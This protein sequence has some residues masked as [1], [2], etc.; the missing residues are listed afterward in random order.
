[1]SKGTKP[2]THPSDYRH[3]STVTVIMPVYNEELFIVGALESVLRSD[4]PPELLEI[5]VADGMSTDGTR[6]LIKKVSAT[7]KVPIKLIDNKKK[8]APS[9]LNLAISAATGDIIVRIDGHCEIESD[10]I[11]NCVRH[12]TSGQAEGVGGPIETIGE[13]NKAKA[14]STAMSSKFGVG[15][16][17]FR[18]IQDKQLYVD[19]VAF[20]GY[21]KSTL[22]KVGPF[23]EELVRNQ[24]D[25]YNFRIRKGGGKILLSPDI[26]SKYFSRATFQ[27]LWKQYFEY[28]FWKIRVLQ[29]HPKQMSPRQFVPFAF[30]VT[31]LSLL[32][33]S[34]FFEVSRWL[35]VFVVATY[36]LANLFATVSVWNRVSFWSL[37]AVSL[38]FLILHF[39]Y[40]LGSLVGLFRF[41]GRWRS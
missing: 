16:S 21:R 5:V 41:A 33:G 26:R 28:G 34:F 20:P 8:I 7:S 14:I 40:G 25:E 38:S 22:E 19:T 17:A 18:T 15:G 11:S 37:P 6:N 27:R 9:A 12:L 30:V 4:Y 23:N 32:I 36:L 10:Y 13:T 1:M 24:D 29:L 3:N 35:L 31:I 2:M 39:S